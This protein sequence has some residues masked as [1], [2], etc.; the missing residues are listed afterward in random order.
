[1]YKNKKYRRM[2]VYIE[3]CFSGSIFEDKIPSN[4]NVFVVT[5]AHGEENSWA[6]FFYFILF[7]FLI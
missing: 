5:A 2:L 4:W 6:K 3:A 7:L 1:M